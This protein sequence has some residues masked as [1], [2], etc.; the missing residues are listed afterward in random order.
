MPR[1]SPPVRRRA[2]PQW[3]GRGRRRR[4]LHHLPQPIGRLGPRAAKCRS[5]S[6]QRR[7]SGCGT[8]CSYVEPHAP[9]DPAGQETTAAARRARQLPHRRTGG[10]GG[11]A[12]RTPRAGRDSRR[13]AARPIS[14]AVPTTAAAGLRPPEKRWLGPASTPAATWACFQ[15]LARRSSSFSPSSGAVNRFFFG[16]AVVQPP[17]SNVV[18]GPFCSTLLARTTALGW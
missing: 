1:C 13:V 14:S 11:G 8:S 3:R 17:T 7:R 16:A 4:Q 9:I 15:R 18:T 2:P 6:A 5:T 12:L 10:S